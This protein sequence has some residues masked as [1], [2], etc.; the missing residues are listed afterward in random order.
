MRPLGPHIHCLSPSRKFLPP[1]AVEK[2]VPDSPLLTALFPERPSQADLR[3]Q[4]QRPGEPAGALRSDLN[5]QSVGKGGGTPNK[6]K[7]L[8]QRSQKRWE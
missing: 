5:K 4:Q 8:R 7:V 6:S 3:T 1:G 2:G